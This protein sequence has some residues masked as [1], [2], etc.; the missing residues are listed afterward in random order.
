VELCALFVSDRIYVLRSPVLILTK[1]AS[2]YT[3]KEPLETFLRDS[4]PYPHSILTAVCMVH[5][6]ECGFQ[7]ARI[8]SREDFEAALA[9]DTL[10]AYV[11]GGWTFHAMKSLQDNQ[12]KGRIAEFIHNCKAFPTSPSDRSSYGFDILQTPLHFVGLY[13]LPMLLIENTL[14]GD[15]NMTTKVGKLSPLMLAAQGGHEALA[16]H[17]LAQTEIQL[18]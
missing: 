17:L 15:P 7:D 12:S 9:G 6:T 1:L 11:S 16:A 2:D 8:G 4:L 18:N 10:L 13:H 14:D 5:L 3:A